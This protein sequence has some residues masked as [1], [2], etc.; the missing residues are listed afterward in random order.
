[1]A[2]ENMLIAAVEIIWGRKRPEYLCRKPYVVR[3]REGVGGGSGVGESASSSGST[4]STIVGNVTT[5]VAG[6]ESSKRRTR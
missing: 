6:K 2:A 3:N 5:E 4:K 1:M